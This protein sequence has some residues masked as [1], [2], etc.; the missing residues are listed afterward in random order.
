MVE[1]KY[2]YSLEHLKS[3][4][5]EELETNVDRR[6]MLNEPPISSGE[7]GETFLRKTF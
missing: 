1:K 5:K 3:N 2:G 7:R 6:L 4:T